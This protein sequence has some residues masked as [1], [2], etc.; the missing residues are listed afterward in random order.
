[1]AGR[2]PLEL[3]VVAAMGATLLYFSQALL[4]WSR[5]RRASVWAQ[6]VT[7][8]L[9]GRGNFVSCWWRAGASASRS[10]HG[11]LLSHSVARRRDAAPP[12]AQ[13]KPARLEL[14]AVVARVQS[15]YDQAKDFQARFTQ[16]YS[17]SVVGA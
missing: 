11:D 1:L 16:K 8:A 17:R 10:C 2:A 9:T 7:L 12:Y 15:R 14:P 3:A 5:L 4:P 6:T 13:A